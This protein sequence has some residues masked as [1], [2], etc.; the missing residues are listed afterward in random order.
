M[1]CLLELDS[2]SIFQLG[3][4]LLTYSS[5]FVTETTS[6]VNDGHSREKT[7]GRELSWDLSSEFLSRVSPVVAL[8]RRGEGGRH[9]VLQ[10]HQRQVSD[11]AVLCSVVGLSNSCPVPEAV[12][13]DRISLIGWQDNG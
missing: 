9:S 5:V 12:T 13:E 3:E 10:P 4:L 11:L 1:S 6:L 8:L 2:P 7:R